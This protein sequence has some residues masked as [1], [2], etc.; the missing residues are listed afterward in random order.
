MGY[1]LYPK[2]YEIEDT[3]YAET[4]EEEENAPRYRNGVAF[5]YETGD[6]KRD[7]KNKLLDC[8]GIESWR[9][10]CINCIQT[11]RYMYLAYSNGYGIETEEA[12]RA[13][14]REEA[15]SILTRQITEAIM[16]DPY[17]RTAYIADIVF[18]WEAPDAIRVNAIIQGVDDVT[19][20]I[21]A[22]ITKGEL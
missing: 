5:D 14:S 4:P 21:V 20:D 22:Y 2:N 11:E 12:F 3:L 1:N 17:Q 9:A 7:G 15:E 19:I 18:V 10:W 16:A 8:H 6:F 13:A